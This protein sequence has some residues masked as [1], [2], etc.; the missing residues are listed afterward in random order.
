MILHPE[1][2]QM[3]QQGGETRRELT[4]WVRKAECQGAESGEDEKDAGAPQ[5]NL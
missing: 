2:F 3:W 1:S 5:G 4:V